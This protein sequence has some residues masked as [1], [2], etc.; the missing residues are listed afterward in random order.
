VQGSGIGVADAVGDRPVGGK[1]GE[2]Q[3]VKPTKIGWCDFVKPAQK[4][5]A[6]SFPTVSIIMAIC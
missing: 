3:D 2:R 4:R 5:M 6:Y 1:R